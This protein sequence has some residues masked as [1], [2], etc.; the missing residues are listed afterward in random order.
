[1]GNEQ[2]RLAINL[3][4]SSAVRKHLEF[5]LSKSE[6]SK[7]I[8]RL[9]PRIASGGGM[10]KKDCNYSRKAMEFRIDEKAGPTAC[11]AYAITAEY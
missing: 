10:T 3:N 2:K 1:M 5:I 7:E 9:R 4:K 8:L 6:T 11:N